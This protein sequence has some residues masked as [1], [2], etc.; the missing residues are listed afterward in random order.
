MQ[1]EMSSHIVAC[2]GKDDVCFLGCIL[3]VCIANHGGE[4]EDL[5]K[6]HN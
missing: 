3:G 4:K 2:A 5:I 1:K 6:M